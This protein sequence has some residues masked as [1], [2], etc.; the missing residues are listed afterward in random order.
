[1]QNTKIQSKFINFN[2]LKYFNINQQQNFIF[3]L[4]TSR[5]SP[6]DTICIDIVCKV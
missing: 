5:F 4:S 2:K 1:M 6:A 3:Q